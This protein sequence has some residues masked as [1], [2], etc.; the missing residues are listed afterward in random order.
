MA[1]FQD[2]PSQWRAALHRC[3]PGL[4]V[5]VLWLFHVI[6]NW[7]WLG[8]NVIMRGWD[9]IGALINSLFYYDT[10]STITLQSLFKASIQDEIRPPLFA[11][12]M[13]VMYKLFGVSSD[14]AIMVNAVY[15]AIL[16]FASYSIGARLGGR[17]QGLLSA[18]LVAF[19]P[20][21][22]AMSR[23]SY[24]EFAVAA[25][26][27]LSISLLLA[28]ERFEKRG[29]ALLL[30]IAL[31]LGLLLKRTFP[32]FVIGAAAV[33]FLQAGLPQKLWARL[34]G[35]PRFRWR[36]LVLALVGGLALSAFWYF[37]NQEL[38]QTLA[39]GFWLFPIWWAIYAF[40]IFFLL[41]PPSAVANFLSC[42]GLAMSVASLW[43]L[44]RS[45]FIQ[46]ALRAG[47]GVDDP[48]GRVVEWT[49]PSTWTDYL[50]SFLY[51]FSPVFALLLLL[52]L[53]LLF[54][55]S[56][57]RKRRPLPS[58]WWDSGW[59][60]VI[61]S[62]GVAYLI[63][64]TSIYKEDRAITP[65][66]PFLSIIMAGAI[67]RLPWRR[68]GAALA[69]VAVVFGLIQFFAISYTETHW[70]AEQ[71][72]FPQPILGQAGLF[73]RGPYLELPDSGLNDPGYHVSPTVLRRVEQRRELEG[74]DS[75][76][77]GIVANSSHVHVGM[78][79]YE[80]L[81]SYPA[82]QVEDPVQAYPHES[83]YSTA[84]QYDYV[85]VLTG[86]SRGT[87]TR[88]AV[89]TILGERR[90]WFE[91]AFELEKVYP[92]PDGNDVLLFRR[93]Q[94][95]ESPHRHEALF[96]VAQYVRQTAAD[97]DAVVVYPPDL[98]IG[99]LQHYWGPA[100]VSGVAS[101]EGFSSSRSEVAGRGGRIFL[102]TDHRAEVLGW[103]EHEPGIQEMEFGELS[104]ITSQLVQLNG[105]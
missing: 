39:L 33:V 31:G 27:A 44:P 81:R 104:V 13:A 80:Q 57:R 103:L 88:E 98:L 70:L 53:G 100:H 59:W 71:A 11:A 12:S 49:N 90:P 14:V 46:R 28:S 21:V 25:F 87:S 41:Q 97:R 92:L 19:T 4:L 105:D 61:A 1:K 42:C 99:I 74:W 52:A 50:Q 3:W 102:V 15:L 40:T 62:L 8:K 91:T 45:S 32:V 26:A 18:V 77:L 86:G 24:F 94:R 10:L 38:A 7:T 56:I 69:S 67:Y 20:L 64:S 35:L 60:A 101:W 9:R 16:L 5:A 47:W 78:F 2:H 63:F 37:P 6:A 89:A 23:Y 55:H 43:Y 65:A 75:I 95:P 84:F 30:G 93:R 48:R 83:A 22:F 76:S 66:L 29:F 17:R 79:A 68:V 54:I 73:G 58:P 72:V 36:D 82:I 85:L 51:G 96:D 34:K